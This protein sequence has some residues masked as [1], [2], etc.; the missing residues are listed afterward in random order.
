MQLST[1]YY[2]KQCLR[3]FEATEDPEKIE[4]LKDIWV[5]MHDTSPFGV[6]RRNA[7]ARRWLFRDTE[8]TRRQLVWVDK[9]PHRKDSFEIDRRAV[10]A[11]FVLG[12]TGPVGALILRIYGEEVQARQKETFAVSARPLQITQ[13]ETQF[14]FG[15][16]PVEVPFGMTS[17][18]AHFKAKIERARALIY[19][20]VYVLSLIHISEPTRP[21]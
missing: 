15:G 8:L 12:R 17:R 7:L 21:Y 14:I 9:V 10:K 16:V 6:Q 18:E 4:K 11:S 1:E 2:T 13:R 3:A 5:I 19:L 20:L